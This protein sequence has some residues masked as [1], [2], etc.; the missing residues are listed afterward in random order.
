MEELL[1]IILNGPLIIV[2][3]LVIALGLVW[4]LYYFV[5]PIIEKNENL[6]EEN[7]KLNDSLTG[8]IKVIKS[9]LENI[10]KSISNLKLLEDI[11]EDTSELSKLYPK[12]ENEISKVSGKIL[13]IK[14]Y[15][16]SS[17][18]SIDNTAQI[19]GILKS[20]ESLERSIEIIKERQITQAGVLSSISSNFNSSQLNLNKK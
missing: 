3:P 19:I 8:E 16:T 2:I 18:R 14:E 20:L 13:E 1:Q 17:R 7:Q 5:F 9:E 11:E 4:V 15:T 10:F 12:I 6:I